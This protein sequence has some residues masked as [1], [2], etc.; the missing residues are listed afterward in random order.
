MSKEN[1]SAPQIRRRLYVVLYLAV[2]LMAAL[3]FRLGWI[4]L[5]MAEELQLKAW[6]QWN[7]SIPA[8]SSRG[9]ILDR[10]GHLLAGSAAAQTIV[11]MPPQVGDPVF[12]SRA[13]APVLEMTEERIMELITQE[14]AAVYL[15]RRVEEDVAGEVRL[16]N[17]PG[18]SFTEEPRRYYPNV[19]LF[20]QLLGFVGTDQGWAGL[21][22]YYEEDLA[23]RDGRIMFPTDNRG[24]EIPGARRLVPPRE[25]KDLYLTVDETIQ[26]FLERELLRAMLQYDAERVMGLAVNPQTGELLAAASKPD[27]DPNHY[28]DY[29]DESWRL[30]P[31]TDTFEPGSTFKLITLSAAL[32]EGL[33][34]EKDLFSCTGSREVADHTVRC[35]TSARGGHGTITYAESIYHSCNPAF[36]ELGERLGV[37]KLFAYIRAFGF[38]SRTGL[39][40]PAE[41]RGQ[42]FSRE[43]VGPVELAT[44]SFG[45]GVSVTPLQQVMAVSAIANGGHLLR[46]YLVKK[47]VD[48]EG[49]TVFAQEPEVIRQVISE[50]TAERVTGLMEGSVLE[51]TGLPAG[52]E[53]YRVAGKTGT[54]QKAFAGGYLQDKYVLSFI[55]FAPVEDP[56]VVLYVAIDGA[57]TG[58]QLGSLVS[59]PLFQTI[60]KDVLSY[61]EI[62]PSQLPA[63]EDEEEEGD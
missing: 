47:I 26:F 8:R 11:A 42:I 61:L 7:R 51:G 55:G 23:G 19:H 21:E 5:V 50:T 10:N 14:R 54:A 37:A 6:E 12:T 59:A 43:E 17:L 58:P 46:P 32:E 53:G 9:D 57:R 52:I 35:W 39:D 27:F 20:S 63:G 38:G 44:S 24:R 25:G 45:Q 31:V 3:V 36:V 48:R 56:R 41:G 4:Q 34:Q 15:K 33:F 29:E 22:V 30:L 40:Y 13:L 60:M 49:N 1:P 16:L 28:N 62:P 2:V 18:I